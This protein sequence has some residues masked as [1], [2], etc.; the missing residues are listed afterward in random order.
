MK[1]GKYTNAPGRPT[2]SSYLWGN[3]SSWITDSDLRYLQNQ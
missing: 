3:E 2:V 1:L